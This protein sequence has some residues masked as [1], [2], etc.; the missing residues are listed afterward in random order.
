ML[1]R[2]DFDVAQHGADVNRF[3]VVTAVIFTQSF[4]AENFMQRR[5]NAKKFIR[6][7]AG[8]FQNAG[9][10][11]RTFP[12]NHRALADCSPVIISNHARLA[13]DAVAGNE[14]GQRILADGCA[15]GARR[16][17]FAN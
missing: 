1:L 13:D 10:S 15:H 17:G 3:A 14:I 6:L 7:P 2:A 16:S 9:K 11:L 12:G 5:K 8:R 4:H